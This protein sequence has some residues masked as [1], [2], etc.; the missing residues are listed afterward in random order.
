MSTGSFLLRGS[1]A[2]C[3]W[4]V[5]RAAGCQLVL[6][7]T[8]LEIN[9]ISINI[10]S[11]MALYSS[12]RSEL[13]ASDRSSWI[14]T[15]SAVRYYTEIQSCLTAAVFPSILSGNLVLLLLS[16]CSGGSQ[17]W[18]STLTRT[19]E[20]FDRISLLMG[21]P[22]AFLFSLLYGAPANRLNRLQ[23]LWL[24]CSCWAIRLLSFSCYRLW[25]FDW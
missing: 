1:C 11:T 19:V 13:V 15:A 24:C 12:S 3:D 20:R 9:Q 10:K 2:T 8:G 14:P 22:S 6:H 17:N 25:A 23:M 4:C 18:H 7:G 5:T 16:L 21:N